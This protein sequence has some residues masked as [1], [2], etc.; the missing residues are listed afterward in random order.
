MQ[1][2]VLIKKVQNLFEGE[3]STVT[4]TIFCTVCYETVASELDDV[5]QSINMCGRLK[6]KSC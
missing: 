3:N 5:K 2:T 4:V 1:R 6:L